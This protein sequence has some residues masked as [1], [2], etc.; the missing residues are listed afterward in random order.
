MIEDVFCNGKFDALFGLKELRIDIIRRKVMLNIQF[1]LI[2]TVFLICVPGTHW[3]K[4]RY[5]REKFDADH[6]WALSEGKV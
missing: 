1:D 5:H 3:V 4:H 6:Y 2:S